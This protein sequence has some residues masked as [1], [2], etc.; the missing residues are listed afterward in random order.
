MKRSG[1]RRLISAVGAFVLGMMMVAGPASAW[2][3]AGHMVISEIAYQRLDPE[4][5]QE[6]ERLVAVLGDF[7]PKNASIR[8]ASLWMDQAQAAGWRSFRR[9][10]YINIPYNAGGLPSVPEVDTDNAVEAVREAMATL[11]NPESPDLAKAIMLRVLLHVAGDLHQPLHATS[12]ITA[13]HPKGDRGGND[14]L[15]LDLEG[16]PSN[17]H[18]LW[19]GTL[20]LLPNLEGTEEDAATVRTL[21][22]QIVS[23]VPEDTLPEWQELDPAVWAQESFHLATSVVYVG[24]SE[25]RAPSEVYQVKSRLVARRRIA[26]AGYRLGALLTELVQGTGYGGPGR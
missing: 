1:S 4:V 5:A 10:H 18:Q 3:A 26:L 2:R 25:G 6:V 19:D 7:E 13:E 15:L 21:A 8:T 23:A 9:W 16:E 14:F 22:K 20:G 24:I 17:L 12:R 11:R